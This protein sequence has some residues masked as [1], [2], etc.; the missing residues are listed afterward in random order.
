MNE[1]LKK[2]IQLYALAIAP[3]RI[4]KKKGPIDECV[5]KLKQDGVNPLEGIER[6]RRGF[7]KIGK[8]RI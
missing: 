6:I 8:I 1:E 3:N 2:L 7:N 4:K 5:K